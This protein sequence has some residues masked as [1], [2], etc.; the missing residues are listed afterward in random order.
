MNAGALEPLL[1]SVRARIS[2]PA[3]QAVAAQIAADLAQLGV[4]H[5]AGEDVAAE[6]MHVEAQGKLLAATEAQA[7]RTAVLGWVET[8]IA[9]LLR[10]ALAAAGAA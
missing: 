8:G 5:L 9:T 7:V 3:R 4:R 10:G 2:D 1:A 6:L